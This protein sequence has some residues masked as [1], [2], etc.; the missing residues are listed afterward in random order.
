MAAKIYICVYTV[1]QEWEKDPVG[2]L[3]KIKEMGYEG[4]EIGLD[5][6]EGTFQA[7][8]SK[9]AEL[10]MSAVGAHINLD[11]AVARTDFYF[12]RMRQLQMKYLGIPWLSDDC[13]PG[14][15]RYAQTKAKIRYMAERCRLEGFVYQYHNHN[16]E[17]EKVNGVCKLDLLL[18]DIPELIMQ[19]DVCWCTVGGQDP[20][21]YIRHYG[22]RMPVLH[23]KDFSAKADVA[24]MKLY[25]LMGK[26][27]GGDAEQTRGG[28]GFKFTPVG[29]G[30][31]DIPSVFKAADEVG[32]AWMGVEQD[33]SPDRPPMEAARLSYEYIK[34]TYLK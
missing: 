5:F 23:I 6:E 22:S 31:V 7:I 16:F 17:F 11:D 15:G 13:L 34:K 3:A 8:K 18:Q 1:Q 24:G 32:V 27:D 28:A 33:A 29:M 30:Q 25:E 19:L 4:V 21:S 14:G 10:G 9:L 2:T 26:N 20:A 12:D